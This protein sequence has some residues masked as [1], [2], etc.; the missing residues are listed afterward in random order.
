M[1]K[2]HL[3]RWVCCTQLRG[4]RWIDGSATFT[5][6]VSVLIMKVE[7]HIAASVHQGR[8]SSVIAA[9][10]RRVPGGGNRSLRQKPPARRIRGEKRADPVYQPQTQGARCCQSLGRTRMGRG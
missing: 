6:G 10:R 4:L 8:F 2:R 1:W 3:L 5:T 9:R 7:E